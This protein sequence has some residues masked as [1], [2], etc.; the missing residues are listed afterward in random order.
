MMFL[1]VAELQE[2]TGRATP[3]AQRRALDAMRIPY[4]RRPDGTPAVLRTTVM[5]LLGPTGQTE[6]PAP[7]LHLA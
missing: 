4:R 3:A 1:T 2:L 6:R 7:R 5:T